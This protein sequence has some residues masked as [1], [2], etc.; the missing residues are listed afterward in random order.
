MSSGSKLFAY[1]P[2]N[3]PCW[4]CRKFYSIV[5]RVYYRWGRVIKL[6]IALRLWFRK[7]NGVRKSRNRKKVFWFGEM[8]RTTVYFLCC[9]KCII[10]I[11]VEN[12]SNFREA[13][14]IWKNILRISLIKLFITILEIYSVRHEVESIEEFF[15][16]ISVWKTSLALIT[17]T[18]KN[19]QNAQIQ[20]WQLT[21]GACQI[22]YFSKKFQKLT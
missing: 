11:Y 10:W 4:C 3:L 12:I 6:F 13:L 8:T 18:S 22:C 7:L 1:I 19:T 15:F 2:A 17:S 21:S 16:N 20:S 14:F 9:R 5:P